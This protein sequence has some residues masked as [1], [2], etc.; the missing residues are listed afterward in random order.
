M[1]GL[2]PESAAHESSTTG[3]HSDREENGGCRKSHPRLHGARRQQNTEASDDSTH[4]G[5]VSSFESQG[6]KPIPC[7]R[8]KPH[9]HTEG[10]P[11]GQE[12]QC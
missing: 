12:G 7:R 11:T 2:P 4:R 10:S 6:V 9:R 5:T 8:K 1:T 3:V